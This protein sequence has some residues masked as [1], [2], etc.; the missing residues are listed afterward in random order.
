MTSCA[1]ADMLASRCALCGTVESADDNV[2]NVVSV[3]AVA[4][5]FC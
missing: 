2:E 3:V 4:F 1:I 5:A